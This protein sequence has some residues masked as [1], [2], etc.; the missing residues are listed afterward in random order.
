ME[1][2]ITLTMIF[3]ETRAMECAQSERMSMTVDSRRIDSVNDH[4]KSRQMKY[5]VMKQLWAHEILRHKKKE[6]RYAEM[7]EGRLLLAATWRNRRGGKQIT[8][9]RQ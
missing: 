4:A 3:L 6:D 9:K 5:L 7:G 1:V 8:S 2:A